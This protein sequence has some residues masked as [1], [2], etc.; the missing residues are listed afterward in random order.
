MR[1]DEALH[2]FSLAMLAYG[3]YLLTL[4]LVVIFALFSPYCRRVLL[5][6][7]LP[8]L[9]MAILLAS[10]VYLMGF[11]ALVISFLLKAAW[12]LGPFLLLTLLMVRAKS[13]FRE[14]G[15]ACN[16][17]CLV[18]MFAQVQPTLSE[19]WHNHQMLNRLTKMEADHYRKLD[20]IQDKELLESLLLLAIKSPQTNT[21]ESAFRYL[22]GRIS[23]FAAPSVGDDKYS[24][25]SFFTLAIK[26][27]NARAIRAFSHTLS[28]DAK[29]TQTNR[30]T[31]RDDNPLF[32][33]Y[34]GLNGDR[35]FGDENL[36]ANLVAARD[37]S[38]TLL[39]LMPELLTE[40]TYAKAIDT[41]DGE[42]LRLLWHRHPPSDPVLRLEAM[43][44]IPETAELTWQ[45]LKQPSLL[46]AT[47]R[48]G[49]R[50]LDFIVRFGNPTAIQAL[51]N[52]RAIDWQRFTAPQE[53]TTP[54][55]LATWRLKYEGD[56]DT[57]RLV[58][59]DMLVQKTPLTDEQI[60]R[61]LTDGLTTED[62]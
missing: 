35:L 21:P 29:Q 32:N 48:S 58:L 53:K 2:Q 47:D 38:T 20:A 34:M 12:I 14:Y 1:N 49:R 36:A 17:L 3:G 25:R 57:W 5:W 50:V 11:R 42:L 43:S 9:V 22:S 52:A 19:A 7:A 51:I 33:M 40:P 16:I 26:H 61:V 23:P 60:A 27:Y 62:F 41:G 10:G 31:L 28:G 54:L 56:N 13:S 8:Q 18:F 6:V 24:T 59:K 4:L 46:E 39:S 44:A 55:L 45:I 15:I 37:I 30:A